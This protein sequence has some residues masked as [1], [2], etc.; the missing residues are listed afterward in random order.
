MPKA[1]ESA[2]KKINLRVRG[3]SII[4]GVILVSAGFTGGYFFGGIKKIALN[5]LIPHLVDRNVDNFSLE[6]MAE[7]YSLIKNNYVGNIDKNAL[8]EQ[9]TAG[10]VSGLNDPY[11]VYMSATQ[12]N[13]LNNELAGTVSG[14]GAEIGIKDNKI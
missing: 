5:G 6:L 12:K 9:A 3:A 14:I 2:A 8:V 4:I 1:K 13:E 10:L 7:V 11:S